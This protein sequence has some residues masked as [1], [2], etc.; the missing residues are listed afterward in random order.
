MSDNLMSEEEAVSDVYPRLL[1]CTVGTV[2][3]PATR[4]WGNSSYRLG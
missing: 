4:S 3:V 1:C 2:C